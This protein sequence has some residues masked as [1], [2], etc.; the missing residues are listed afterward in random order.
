VAACWLQDIALVALISR[1]IRNSGKRL[2]VGT[3]AFVVYCW[4]L[5]SSHCSMNV[6]RSMLSELAAYPS[7]VVPPLFDDVAAG[8]IRHAPMV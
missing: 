3:V 6:L 5:S 2:V 8:R 1:H 4:W 7:A